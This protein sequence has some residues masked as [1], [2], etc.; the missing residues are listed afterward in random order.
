MKNKKAENL[1]TNLHDKTEYV[2]HI[3]NLK[4]ELIHE[5]QTEY[6]NHI[7]NLKQALIHELHGFFFF[8]KK[9]V[10]QGRLNVS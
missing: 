5:L 8:F 10:F 2:N 1:V 9:H 6:V 4:Q 3:R 7:R